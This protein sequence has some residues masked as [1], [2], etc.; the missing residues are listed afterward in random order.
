MGFKE[1]V[2]EIE[3]NIDNFNMLT[4][5]ITNLNVINSIELFFKNLNFENS[6]TTAK[7]FLTSYLIIHFPKEI[8]VD[9]AND[10]LVNATKTMFNNFKIYVESDSVS[11]FNNFTSSFNVFKNVFEEWKLK[12]TIKIVDELIYQFI[13]FESL[14]VSVMFNDNADDEWAPSIQKEQENIIK[15][16][17]KFGDN[18][19]ERLLEQRNIQLSNLPLEFLQNVRVTIN[20]LTKEILTS[21]HM[22]T[23]K[24]VIQKQKLHVES[25]VPEIEI[26]R[27]AAV[28]EIERTRELLSNERLAHE[29]I[30]DPNFSLKAPELSPT[31]QEIKKIAK[32]AM[33]DIID[34]ELDEKVNY[35]TLYELLISIKNGLID[36]CTNKDTI[37]KINESLDEE[38]ILYQMKNNTFDLETTFI[39]ITNLMTQLCAPIRDADITNL[40]EKQNEKSTGTLIIQILDILDNMKLDLAN[41]HLQTIKPHLIR[42]SVKYEQEKFEKGIQEF[43]FTKQWLKTAFDEIQNLNSEKINYE[44]I[45]DSAY[46]NILFQKVLINIPETLV[47][48]D[49]RLYTIRNELTKLA[50]IQSICIIS[51]N[52]LDFNQT[53]IESLKNNLLVN[54]TKIT[55]ETTV[56]LI[57]ELK[58]PTEKNQQDFETLTNIIDKIFSGNEPLL[59]LI[60]RRIQNIIT[61]STINTDIFTKNGLHDI[62]NELIVLH[63]SISR[64]FKYNKQ[65]Y[66]KYYNKIIDELTVDNES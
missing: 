34:E 23:R 7:L 29:L 11:N 21:N 35:T 60:T 19:I 4:K 37:T 57:K 18:N 52:M 17:K 8:G 31:E 39:Y 47:L 32:K 2:G 45:L 5:K 14:W 53:T 64:L 12:D 55:T 48:D 15:R 63:S 16:I 50:K 59:S 66:A 54:F 36:C 33:I 13:E 41:Y 38:F 51:K 3:M 40:I 65:V 43:L 42:D 24:T 10:A 6:K 61:K 27:A 25:N 62:S 30:M 56:K 58:K 9:D 28:T 20:P 1:I 46:L 44:K 22:Y 49:S 26:E